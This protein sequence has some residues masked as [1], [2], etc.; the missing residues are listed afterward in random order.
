MLLE[1]AKD[2]WGNTPEAGGSE[3]EEEEPPDILQFWYSWGGNPPKSPH[4]DLET[5]DDDLDLSA[6]KRLVPILSGD[7]ERPLDNKPQ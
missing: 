3:E 1:E 7:V 2:R 6:R 4:L 5:D